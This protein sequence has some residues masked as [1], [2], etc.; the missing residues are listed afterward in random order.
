MKIQ[1]IIILA[2]IL[3]L[4]L[5]AAVAKVLFVKEPV[6]KAEYAKLNIVLNPAAVCG[7][8]LKKGEDKD[9]I[10][11]EKVDDEWVITS[12]WN[13]RAKKSSID[14]LLNAVQAMQGELRSSDKSVLG[15]YGITEDKGFSVFLYDKDGKPLQRFVVGTKLVSDNSC[16]I[17]NADSAN[18]YLLNK[19]I[20][21]AIGVFGKPEEAKVDLTCWT[22]TAL[23]KYDIEKI[24]GVNIARYDAGKKTVSVGLKRELDKE[25]NLM[26]WV[27]PGQAFP[28]EIDAG[29]IKNYIKKLTETHT[30][31]VIDPAGT[32]FGFENP[33]LVITLFKGEEKPVEIIVGALEKKDGTDR[34]VKTSE[35]FVFVMAQYTMNDIAY[36]IAKFFAD[37]PLK[38][39]KDKIAL[40]TITTPDKTVTL[41]KDLIGKNADYIDNK[42]KAFSAD[43]MLEAKDLAA[44]QYTLVV[45]FQDGK[46]MKLS[47]K[48]EDPDKFT[49][50]AST[51]PGVFA[52][53]KGAFDK[54][55]T[56]LDSLKLTKDEPAKK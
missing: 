15:D 32:G 52:I 26:Q 2:V 54:I 31:R 30:S 48:K 38:I 5:T 1:Q 24:D 29:K 3:G 21:S 51:G 43:K 25:K 42:L 39:D 37:N 44:P 16:F 56:G 41:D 50:K 27:A 49:A 4:L 11:I 34:Y 20:F 10:K 19:E 7:I 18:V 22:D 12:K 36:H 47:V 53:S 46:V 14:D 40:I 28:F 33:Y 55:F 8:E 9:I 6:D 13:V 45:T 17:R 35:G 23:I